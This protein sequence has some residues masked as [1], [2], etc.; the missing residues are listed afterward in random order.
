MTSMLFSHS[1]VALKYGLKSFNLSCNDSILVPDFVCDVV[2]Q[3]L[4]D[5]NISYIFYSLNDNL[6]PDWKSVTNQL[7]I[8]TK[9]IL[10]IHYFG[11][12]QNIEDFQK[13][14]KINNLLLIEDNAHGFGGTLNGRN[15][16]TFGDIGFNSP[17]KTLNLISGGQLLLKNNQYDEINKTL[18]SLP[19]L[20]VFK[21]KSLFN[22]ALN[23]NYFLKT[24]LR[25]LL[26]KQPKYWNPLAFN[27]SKVLDCRI[28]IFSE[29]KLESINFDKIYKKR[30][31]LY[32]IWEKFAIKKGAIPVFDHLH[33]GIIPLVFA[34]YVSS[35]TERLGWFNW[36][37]KNRYNVHSW[38]SLPELVIQ[39]KKPGFVQW[40]KMICF[41]IDLNMETD[42]LEKQLSKL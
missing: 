6:T 20:K 4:R 33:D 30:R 11:Y 38:P 28:D 8:N 7:T 26:K 16:G 29:K 10:M 36:G 40:E 31:S 12:P 23:Y 27:E 19:R 18:E 17:R 2:L 3:P 22:R 5:L 14:C 25:F 21:I 13:F 41:P 35:E 24:Q 34:A 1:R 37:W 15:L 42:L 9:A 32:L 39:E